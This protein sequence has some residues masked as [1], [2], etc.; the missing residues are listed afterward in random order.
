MMRMI[1]A[2]EVSVAVGNISISDTAH[3]ILQ[4]I[5]YLRMVASF[6]YLSRSHKLEES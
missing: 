3:F 5:S 2:V 4:S 1:R 6:Y